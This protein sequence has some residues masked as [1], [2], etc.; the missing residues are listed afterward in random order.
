MY[1]IQLSLV[2]TV[3]LMAAQLE[4]LCSQSSGQR[5]YRRPSTFEPIQ[6]STAPGLKFLYRSNG[7]SIGLGNDRLIVPA[8]CRS[9]DEDRIIIRWLDVHPGR[10]VNGVD[11]L[12]S[13]VHYI[14]G[15]DP[16]KWRTDIPQYARLIY[17]GLYPG[18]DLVF[19]T[20]EEGFEHD[21]ILD[22]GVDPGVIRFSVIGARR[23]AADRHGNLIVYTECDDWNMQA[24]VAYQRIGGKNISVQS[25][26]VVR[27]D[28][29]VQFSV[30]SYDRQTPLI[31]DPVIGFATRVAGNGEYTVHDMSLDADGNVYVVGETTSTDLPLLSPGQSSR[32]GKETFVMGFDRAGQLDFSTYLGGSGHDSASCIEVDS[33]GTMYVGGWTGSPDFPTLQAFQ[34]S[35]AGTID[36]FVTK[37]GLGGGLL[38]STYLGGSGSDQVNDV[39]VDGKGNAY[40]VGTTTSSDFPLLKSLQPRRGPNDAFVTALDQTG[41]SLLFSTLFGGSETDWGRAID[42]GR[43]E[44]FVT[45]ST[46]SSDFPVESAL[47]PDFGGGSDVFVVGMRAAEPEVVFS[48]YLG[49]AG[50]DYGH[51]LV[52]GPD[53]NLHVTGTGSDG[54]PGFSPS[55][56]LVDPIHQ[57]GTVFVGTIDPE[58]SRLMFS[59]FYGRG[60][61]SSIAADSRGRVHVVGWTG[62]RKFPQVAPLQPGLTRGRGSCPVFFF[63]MIP[64]D[65]HDAFVF[66][67][68]PSERRVVFA[69]LLGESGDDL[70]QAIAVDGIGDLFVA[71]A[72][73]PSW[74]T[75]PPPGEEPEGVFVFKISLDSLLFPQFADGNH[76]GSPISSEVTLVNLDPLTEGV[77]MLEINDDDGEPM[78]VDLGGQVVEGRKEVFIAPG[79]SVRIGTDGLGPLQV[80]SVRVHSDVRLA[81]FVLYRSSE[82]VAGVAAS[83]SLVRFVSPVKT[84]PGIDSGI[85]LMSVGMGASQITLQL[86]DRGGATVATAELFLSARGQTAKRIGELDW[87]PPMDLTDFSGTLEV[88]GTQ[89]FAATAIRTTPGEYAT[90]PVAELP[91]SER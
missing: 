40:V 76:A 13:V 1:A 91:A 9:D 32:G 51:D 90:L 66:S 5:F 36:G 48:T 16:T 82:G 6:W 3:V 14:A 67:L 42:V 59:T 73:R 39:G 33:E 89:A 74:Y 45:G 55:F 20:A 41:E 4:L 18:V 56:P 8:G 78:T 79:G 86:R 44:V 52:L 63:T 64:G 65:C 12:G 81:G 84:G 47:Q 71:G 50:F 69:T 19:R 24:P 22:P 35:N 83:D 88:N 53:G 54:L 34:D 60:T 23:I 43:E 30:G 70:G 85:A 61:P 25:K 11:P 17:R 87:Q 7:R 15:N 49:G 75:Q 62:D 57:E 29:T 2:L 58:G 31:I 27:P 28:K 26:Y 72:S 68:D 80:G 21:Y 77:A 10:I 38:S 37:F 46:S